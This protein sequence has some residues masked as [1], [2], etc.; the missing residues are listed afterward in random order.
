VACTGNHCAQASFGDPCSASI[1]CSYQN[2][3]TGDSCLNGF[4]CIPSQVPCTVESISFHGQCCSN[5]SLT[6][7]GAG[8]CP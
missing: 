2:S 4:C 8:T 3:S 5:T 1:P 6:C 7:P